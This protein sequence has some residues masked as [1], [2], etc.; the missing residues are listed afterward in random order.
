MI[1]PCPSCDKS[2]EVDAKLIPDTGRLLKCGAC[3]KTWFFNPNLENKN[4]EK[5]TSLLETEKK[6]ENSKIFKNKKE[7]FQKNLKNIPDNKGSELIKYDKKSNFSISNLFNY[8]LIIIIS[9]IALI[10]ILDTFKNQLSIIFPNL[11]LMLYNLFESLKDLFLF[12][13][14]LN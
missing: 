6:L 4:T 5:K 14:D 11:E 3:S 1:I 12:I 9:S 2:F 7:N 13:K 8:L 10:I